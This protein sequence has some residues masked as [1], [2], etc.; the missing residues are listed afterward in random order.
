MIQVGEF[1]QKLAT[2]QT[3][4]ISRA[5]SKYLVHLDSLIDIIKQYSYLKKKLANRR[6]DYDAKLS[7]LQKSKK[8]KPEYE[9]EMKTAQIKYEESLN[10][11]FNLMRIFAEK[12]VI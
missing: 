5:R 12:E 2:Y 10:D 4:F 3:E 6:L 11:L 9:E 8:E 1:E 7:K